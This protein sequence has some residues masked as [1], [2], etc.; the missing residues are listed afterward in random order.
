M[1]RRNKA[2]RNLKTDARMTPYDVKVKGTFAEPPKKE[3]LPPR[4][5]TSEEQRANN[6]APV[7]FSRESASVGNWIPLFRKE[8]AEMN[9]GKVGRPYSFCDSMIFWIMALQTLIRGTYR[10]AA[11]LAAAILGDH[12]MEAP[13]YSR[14]FE[15]SAEMLDRMLS[16][17][18]GTYI[19]RA[20]SNVIDSPR[21]VGIN[22]SGFNLSNTCL[23]RKEKWGTGPKRRG[24]LK[25][26]V[27]SDVDTGEVIAFA[28]TDKNTG[29]SPLMIPLLDAAVAAGHRIGTVY[30][31]G[32]YSSAENF[33]HVCGRLGTRFV[34]SFK[35]NTKP[36]NGGSRYRGEATRLWCS[37]PYAEWVEKSGYGR[38]WKSECGFSDVKRLFGES[39]HAFTMKGAVRKLLMKTETF[40]RYKEQR[41][42]LLS[43]CLASS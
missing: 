29:D 41:A 15:R 30:A 31:D 7:E 33:D 39:I 6:L 24:W 14:L 32:A 9:S 22:S 36:V 8:L 3:K 20:G 4:K 38:R 11:G 21:N 23:W 19:I 13:S 28:V 43:G 12:G 2:Q 37:M 18:G 5:P 25:L 40:S 1:T 26:H 34:T 16:E 10:T 35:V 27:L 17:N 42:I